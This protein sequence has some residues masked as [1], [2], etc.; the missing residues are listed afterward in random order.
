MIKKIILALFLGNLLWEASPA[1]ADFGDADFPTDTFSQGAK[2]YHDSWCRQIKNECRIRFQGS[3]MWVEGQ[4][5]IKSDQ[6][7]SFRYDVDGNEFYNYLTYRSKSGQQKV[8]LFLFANEAAQREFFRAFFMWKK[9]VANPT[10][11]YRLPASQGPQETHGRDK[12]VN[13]Y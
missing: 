6:Y 13:P 7:V 4:G 3:G 1:L 12:G 5:G 9:Q 2:S 11:N 10:P 8:A